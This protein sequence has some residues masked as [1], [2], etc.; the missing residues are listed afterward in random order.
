MVGGGGGT[1]FMKKGT[2]CGATL[3]ELWYNKMTKRGRLAMSFH[4]TC[5]CETFYV[6]NVNIL[7]KDRVGW[8]RHDSPWAH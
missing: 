4:R 1:H 7:L 2:H 5:T 6:L 8:W 3:E